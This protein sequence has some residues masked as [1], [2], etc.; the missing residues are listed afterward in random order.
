MAKKAKVNGRNPSRRDTR[1]FDPWTEA[2]GDQDQRHIDP[3][4]DT[5]GYE[6]DEGDLEDQAE[7]GD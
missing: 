4:W 3:E 7:S 6:S 5:E 2:F 1:R